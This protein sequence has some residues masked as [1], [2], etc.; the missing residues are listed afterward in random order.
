MHQH[1]LILRFRKK[2]L[3][4]P[5]SLNLALVRILTFLEF[6]ND[7]YWPLQPRVSQPLHY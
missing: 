1:I 5:T 4:L 6:V 3:L 2:C 7:G